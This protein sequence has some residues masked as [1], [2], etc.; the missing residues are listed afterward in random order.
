MRVRGVLGEEV[1]VASALQETARMAV[2]LP[3]H[4]SGELHQEHKDSKTMVFP[5]ESQLTRLL[6]LTVSVYCPAI[7]VQNGAEI[8]E[9]LV[10]DSS[11]SLEP[12]DIWPVRSLRTSCLWSVH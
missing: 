6:L 1:V 7:A 2:W 11:N 5:F 10:V 12:S 4:P 9:T 8:D 3:G